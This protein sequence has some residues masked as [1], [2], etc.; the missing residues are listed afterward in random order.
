MKVRYAIGGI[1]VAALLALPAGAAARQGGPVSAVA[2]Q[3]CAQERASIGKRAF[4]KRYGA[5]HTMRNCIKR[6]RP[7]AA[8]VLA[9]A[10]QTCQQQLAQSGPEQFILDYAFDEDTVENAMS[11][12]V[13]DTVDAL[14]YP[15]DA[16]DDDP[17]DEE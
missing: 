17:D 10:T 8:S 4:R 12:C 11:E 16:E 6:S 1:L 5:R 2:A 13:A 7:K 15:G 14:L 3:H 9:S